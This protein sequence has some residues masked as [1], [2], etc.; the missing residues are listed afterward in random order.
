V[1]DFLGGDRRTGK[2][3][4]PCHDDGANPS[5]QV[6]SG[7]KVP[8]VIHCFG[9]N[10]REHDLEALDYLRA[11]GVWPTSDALVREQ[12]SKQV[13]QAQSPEDRRLHALGL[14]KGLGESGKRF[15][16]SL[17]PYFNARG[18]QGVPNEWTK[19]EANPRFVVT[20]L[21]RSR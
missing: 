18:I 6:G 12:S 11:N 15:R 16:P 1:I 14:W 8:V 5:L 13:E 17:G 20:S 10:S 3:F 7:H 19:G 9:L 2:C 21:R 4:C